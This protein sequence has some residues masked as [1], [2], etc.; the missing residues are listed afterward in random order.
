MQAEYSGAT[1][2]LF[3]IHGRYAPSDC[4]P[5][6][7][8]MIAILDELNILNVMIKIKVCDIDI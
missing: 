8:Y 4:C 3:F 7:K 1:M 5:Y 2:V 6:F